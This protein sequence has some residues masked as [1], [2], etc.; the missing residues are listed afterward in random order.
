MPINLE[1]HWAK[2]KRSGMLS[3][4]PLETMSARGDKQLSEL[5]FF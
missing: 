4:A 1:G 3:S 5:H 2:L